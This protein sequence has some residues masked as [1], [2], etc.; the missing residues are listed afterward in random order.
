[1]YK[2]VQTPCTKCDVYGVLR[3]T[4]IWYSGKVVN[5][6]DMAK[7]KGFKDICITVYKFGDIYLER[8]GEW[9]GGGERGV[10]KT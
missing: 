9:G 1:M 6:K 5:G 2:N 8:K 3:Y 7:M 10:I 4:K